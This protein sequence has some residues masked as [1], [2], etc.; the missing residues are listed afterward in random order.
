M[1]SSL[2]RSDVRHS[3]S[4]DTIAHGYYSSGYAID[5]CSAD[6]QHITLC[7]ARL[8]I[9]FSNSGTTSALS[10]HIV[11][12]VARSP[13]KEMH[14]SHT[15]WIVTTMTYKHSGGDCPI[16]QFPCNAMRAALCAAA[17]DR[18]I[19]FR[20]SCSSPQPTVARFIHTGPESFCYSSHCRTSTKVWPGPGRVA[21]SRGLS[22]ILAQTRGA[23]DL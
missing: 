21:A 6:L 12:V 3:V 19:S 10:N 1:F 11:S 15:R 2:T 23:I 18:T 17:F 20:D 8:T 14:R 13:K 5:S 9:A 4:A 7:Q 22:P 16:G